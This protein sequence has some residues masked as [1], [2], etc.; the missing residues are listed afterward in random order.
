MTATGIYVQTNVRL[1]AGGADLTSRSNKVELALEVEDKETTNYGSGGSKERIGGLGSGTLNG[2]GQWEAG[3]LSM[4]DDQNWAQMGSVGG[5]TACPV[6]AAVGSVAWL[7][8]AMQSQYKL[9]DQV[10]NVAPWTAQASSSWPVSRG[11]VLHPAGTART[12]TG[13]GTATLLT[14]VSAT[15]Y[16]YSTL[17][18]YSVT[19]GTLTVKVQSSVDN[20]FASPTDRIT[21]TAA[22][23]LGGQM[24]RLVGP[25]TDTWWRTSWTIAGG[26]THSF[27]FLNAIGIK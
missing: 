9:G 22:T 4:V 3:D 13:T 18:V 19:D 1:F 10:G 8:R 27:L 2:E 5:F 6:G 7:V 25:V 26:S 12:T 17:H 21:F 23:S 16:L 15:Q 11:L 20:T 24:Q 14:A